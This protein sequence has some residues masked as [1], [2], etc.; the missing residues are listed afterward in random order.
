VTRAW[1]LRFGRT[2]ALVQG[3]VWVA[4]I[5]G[6][7]LSLGWAF[8]L[9]A[10]AAALA[11]RR[12]P[13]RSA[14]LLLAP[15]AVFALVWTASLSRL[16]RPP[17]PLEVGQVAA[18]VLPA[19]LGCLLIWTSAPTPNVGFPA[20]RCDQRVIPIR[21]GVLSA[22][23]LALLAIAPVAFSL[24]IEPAADRIA[25]RGF[26]SGPIDWRPM[27]PI[28][29]VVL[30]AVVVFAAAM[31]GGA[32]GTLAWRWSRIGSGVSALVSAWATA[33]VAIP[34]AAA[35]LGIHLRTGI[36]CIMGCEALLRDDQPLGGVMAYAEFLMGTAI[37]VSPIIG[38]GAIAAVV[39]AAASVRRRNS[40]EAR[41]DG[42]PGIGPAPSPR[43]RRLVLGSAISL[44]AV[45]HG[46]GIGLTSSTGQ[47]GLIPY[48]C[49]TV[50]VVAWA[51][52]IDRRSPGRTNVGPDGGDAVWTS[53]RSQDASTATFAG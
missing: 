52:W 15:A 29:A 25:N 38:L 31:V 44:F 45:V 19:V 11:G 2:L 53:E 22:V 32:V 47:T 28:E 23:A 46:A 41:P 1:L 16:S 7:P 9:L 6:T 27:E 10:L 51:I 14:L 35:A 39:W 30:S 12:F 49:L 20:A 8:G 18:L 48:V 33:I 40:A 3:G 42:T 26:A 36:V 13:K 5:S 21:A 43:K 37:I 34:L 50:G 17:Q 24:A 4:T